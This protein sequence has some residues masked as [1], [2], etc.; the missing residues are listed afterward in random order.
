VLNQGR[1]TVRVRPIGTDLVEQSAEVEL[2]GTGVRGQ[3][4][5]DTIQKD[6]Y[7]KPRKNTGIV[8]FKNAVIYA[9]DV[10]KDAEKLFKEGAADIGSG[11]IESGAESLGKAIAIFPTYFSALQQLGAVRLS[12]GKFD[13]AIGLFKRALAVNDR[14]FDSWYGLGF[15]NYSTRRFPEAAAASEKAVFLQA[16]SLEANLLYGMCSR[17]VKDFPNAEKALKRA[18]KLAEVPSADVHWQLALLYGKDM[19]RFAEAAKEL[20]RYLELIPDAPDKQKEDVKK[21]IKQFKERARSV[22]WSPRNPIATRVD[23]GP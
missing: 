20:E 10:P 17:I 7:L 22:S 18:A 15:A 16:D 13:E 9:Q 1:Y 11:R 6:F 23:R 8:P 2:T 4:L 21:L 19:T 14:G 12:Q 5:S 3:P